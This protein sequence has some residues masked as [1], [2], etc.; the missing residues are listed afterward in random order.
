MMRQ[1]MRGQ[2]ELLASR[3]CDGCGRTTVPTGM[4]LVG[5][6]N[7][8]FLRPLMQGLNQTWD[9][10]L[11]PWMGTRRSSGG[12]TMWPHLAHDWGCDECGRDGC[13]CRCCIGD[14]D[15]LVYARLGEQRV[16]P[17]EIENNRR[18]ERQI[19]LELSEWTARGGKSAA[20]AVSAS[21][22]PGEQFT[23]G[24]CEERAATLVVN[25]PSGQAGLEP[26]AEGL[27]DVD[28]CEVFYADLRIE[29][30]DIRPIRIALALLPRDCDAY[31][32]ECRCE[33]C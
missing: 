24:P 25:I 7:Q 29:G 13:H 27:P 17:L 26:G 19:R 18:R 4:D 20:T 5:Q 16:V 6:W 31:E 14:A 33:C 22:Q 10:I 9:A 28:D 11:E 1:H 2:G 21:V 32:V 15:L 30:C 8:M 3:R 12:W 23:L